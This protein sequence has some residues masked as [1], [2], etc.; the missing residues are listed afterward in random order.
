METIAEPGRERVEL[1]RNGK[2]TL[3]AGNGGYAADAHI[4]RQNW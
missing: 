3:H 1:Y 4:L 2:K